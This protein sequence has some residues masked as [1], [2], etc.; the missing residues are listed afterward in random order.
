[1]PYFDLVKKRIQPESISESQTEYLVGS[2][3]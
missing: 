1:M 3:S 2:C